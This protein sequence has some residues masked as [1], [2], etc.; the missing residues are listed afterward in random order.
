MADPP[1]LL[2]LNSLKTRIATLESKIDGVSGE[3]GEGDVV[4]P[5]AASVNA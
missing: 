3:A 5:P 2:E 1:G 4:T